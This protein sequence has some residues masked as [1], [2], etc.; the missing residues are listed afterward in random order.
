[1]GQSLFI[2]SNKM[3][4]LA[5]RKTKKARTKHAAATKGL[6]FQRGDMLFH[7]IHGLCV[8]K[9][10][11]GK[12]GG[13]EGL[14]YWIEPARPG[15]HLSRYF[16]GVHQAIQSGF[17]RPIS[18]KEIETIFESF[19]CGKTGVENFPKENY[20]FQLRTVSQGNTAPVFAQVLLMAVSKQL[21]C[22]RGESKIVKRAAEALA[23]EIAVVLKITVEKAFSLIRKHLRSHLT[24]HPWLGGVLTYKD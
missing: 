17:H 14:S 9:G 12:S 15:K 1:M 10:I 7:S 16:V 21:Y 23:Q 20:S 19:R 13:L 24:V 22:D 5:D 11:V 18:K 6:P 8:V 3:L 2:R 4:D